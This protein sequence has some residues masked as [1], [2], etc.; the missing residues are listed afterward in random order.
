MD[1]KKKKKKMVWGLSIFP[2]MKFVVQ[3]ESPNKKWILFET[4]KLEKKEDAE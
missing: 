2:K 3:K 4:K 1:K